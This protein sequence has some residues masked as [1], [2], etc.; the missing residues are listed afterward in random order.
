MS[1]QFDHYGVP[2]SKKMP[3]ATYLEGAKVHITDPEKHPFRIEFLYFEPG[4]P[5]LEEVQKNTHVAFI[6]PSLAEAIEGQNVIIPPFDAT[7]KLR[8]A[9]IKDG[10]AIIEV[11]ERK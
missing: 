1:A 5:M 8:C 7:D 4:S 6:V 2:T 10:E 3:G 11:M 9:F